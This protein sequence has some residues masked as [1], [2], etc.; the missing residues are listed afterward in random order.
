[1]NRTSVPQT[2][3]NS[4]QP[5]AGLCGSFVLDHSPDRLFVDLFP[6]LLIIAKYPSS[7]YKDVSRLESLSVKVVWWGSVCKVVNPVS[8][9]QVA[10]HAVR[11]YPDGQRITSGMKSVVTLIPIWIALVLVW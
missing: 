4:Y 11:E 3:P 7:E 8:P 5:L 10:K 6:S 1:M 9:P 2:N